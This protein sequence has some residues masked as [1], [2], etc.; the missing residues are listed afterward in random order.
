MYEDI[1]YEVVLGRILDRISDKFDKREGA[2]IYDTASPTAIELQN[3]Y[4]ELDNILKESFG[5]TASRDYL[6]LRCQERG[7]MPYPATN[8]VLQG[9][10]I[11]V[12]IDMTGKRFNIDALNYT[13]IGM[14]SA[15]VYRVQ[16]ETA[17]VIGNQFLGTM[18][19]IDY[20]SGLET[21][22]L[23]AVLIPGEDEE[24]TEALRQRYFDSFGIKAFGGN[25][26]DYIDNVNGISGVG[27][28]KVE[29]VWNADI[30]PAGMIPSE[31]V[32]TWYAG[33]I[34]TLDAE[35][36]TW[37]T[38]VYMAGLAGKLTTGGT[39]LITLID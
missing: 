9:E 5:A 12:T 11:P 33:I 39:V 28:C 35:T 31:N 3:L 32:Q 1:T 14:S 16:C 2:I 37:I 22:Q 18:T 21:A 7:I 20:V 23:T 10:F 24:D 29:R 38:N 4:V 8:A 25:R 27:A 15:G 26:Q 17:G 13:V 36:S 30:Q 19:P 34:D 6:I